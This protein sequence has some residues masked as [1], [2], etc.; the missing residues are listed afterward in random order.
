[1]TPI[2][3][4]SATQLDENGN[5][6]Y[7]NPDAPTPVDTDLIE[8]PDIDSEEETPDEVP[9]PE[10]EEDDK[11]LTLDEK[12]TDYFTGQTGVEAK[13]FAEIVMAVRDVFKEVGGAAGLKEGLAELKNVRIAQQIVAKQDELATLW[14]VDVKETQARLTEIK[15]YFNKLSKADKALYDNP[16]GADVL[17]RSLQAD[18]TKTKSAKSSP[19]SR[20]ARYLFSQAQIDAMPIE[21]YRANADKITHAYNN[22]LVGE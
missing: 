7:V 11:P 5:E 20:G 12:F 2:S 15:P 13:E 21:E 10:E 3:D 22:G 16:K 9:L 1:L 18:S 4:K 19:N 14:G 8:L 6:V 17:W